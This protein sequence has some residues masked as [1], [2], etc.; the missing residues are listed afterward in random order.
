MANPDIN[1]GKFTKQVIAHQILK[2][3][4]PNEN[5]EEAKLN[6]ITKVEESHTTHSSS[7]ID[8]FQN[9][10]KDIYLFKDDNRL[11]DSTQKKM[12]RSNSKSVAMTDMSDP[13]ELIEDLEQESPNN[14]SISGFLS[15][16]ALKQSIMNFIPNRKK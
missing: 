1:N 3:F 11:I 9:N 7:L 4:I 8:I 10:K 6:F 5:N 13:M 14:K 12:S 16:S 2:R 15:M